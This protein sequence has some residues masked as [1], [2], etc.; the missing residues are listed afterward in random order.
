MTVSIPGRYNRLA[1]K[2]LS[3]K[4]PAQ[5]TDAGAE[6]MWV[7]PLF[8]GVENRFLEQW[9]R[10]LVGLGIAAGGAGNRSATR[11]RNPAGSNVIAIFEKLLVWGTVADQPALSLAPV[12][13][14]LTTVNA[15]TQVR[16]DARGRQQPTLISSSTGNLG[17]VPATFVQFAFAANNQIDVIFF[18]EQEIT[19]LPGDALTIFSNVLNQALNVSAF[20]RERSLEDSELK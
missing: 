19:L 7:F 17:A 9:D 8:F 16:M 11:F 18:E 3:T 10:F 4:G 5:I 13:T 15:L 1:Q 6:L 20:W 2:L 12:S 14:D